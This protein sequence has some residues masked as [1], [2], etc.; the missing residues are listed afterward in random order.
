[1]DVAPAGW[2][3]AATDDAGLVALGDRE[4]LSL[5]VA[6]ASGMRCMFRPFKGGLEKSCTKI[7]KQS[8][9]SDCVENV[10]TRKSYSTPVYLIKNFEIG[11]VA[12]ELGHFK[13]GVPK[14]Y[15]RKKSKK[16]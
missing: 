5:G 16:S 8:N 12:L 3:V 6:P 13:D 10:L 2:C 11:P 14:K 7:R 15:F 9:S 1:M 4:P